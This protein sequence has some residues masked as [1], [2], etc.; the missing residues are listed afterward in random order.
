[1]FFMYDSVTVDAI[2]EKPHAVAAYINGEY[3]TYKEVKER[4]P[5]TRIL[6]I[7]V[8][9]NIPAQCYDVEAGDYSIDDVPE[10]F[11]VAKEHDVWRPCFYADLSNMPEVKKA[12]NSVEGMTRDAVRL[13]VAYYT[14]GT[15]ALPSGYDA[16]QFTKTALDRNL[17]ESICATTFFQAEKPAPKPEPPKPAE[18]WKAEVTVDTTNGEWTVRGVP[19]DSKPTV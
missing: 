11:K 9:G 4:F 7:S 18:P 16:H 13:W 15:P 8:T 17:D 14:D 12:L 19:A 1:M 5:D 2:P 3:E 6:Q 10:L